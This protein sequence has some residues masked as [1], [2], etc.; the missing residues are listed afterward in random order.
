ML[1]ALR[2]DRREVPAVERGDLLDTETLGDRD[3]RGVRT[4]KRERS[5]RPHQLGHPANIN[6]GQVDERER[7][8]GD[9][10]EECGLNVGTA[11]L[12]EPVADLGEN[13]RWD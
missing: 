9:G 11:V 13:R 6:A 7:P 3:D 2:P 10:V 5:E 1:T 8:I 12:V 4:A